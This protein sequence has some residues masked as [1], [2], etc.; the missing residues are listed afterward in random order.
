MLAVARTLSVLSVLLSVVAIDSWRVHFLPWGFEG[1]GYVAGI[2]FVLPVLFSLAALVI[3]AVLAH[4][5]TRVGFAQVVLL[6]VIS[7]L[8]LAALVAECP[9]GC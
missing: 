1:T 3:V 4:S 2:S 7:L 6:S 5:G 8:A 9:G